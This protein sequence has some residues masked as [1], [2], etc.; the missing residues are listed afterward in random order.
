LKFRNKIK[1]WYFRPPVSP[2]SPMV[3]QSDLKGLIDGDPWHV[4]FVRPPGAQPAGFN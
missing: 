4:S 3:L 1:I 2:A